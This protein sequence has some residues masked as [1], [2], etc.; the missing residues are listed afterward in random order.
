M[1]HR[2]LYENLAAKTGDDRETIER[3]G[4]ELH[5]PTFEPDRKESK[6]L[7]RLRQWRQARRDRRLADL[8]A[9][10]AQS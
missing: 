4:F 2:E 9:R 10:T 1:S 7:R 3:L 5:V 8:A 6:R